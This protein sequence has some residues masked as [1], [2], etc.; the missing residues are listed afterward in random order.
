MHADVVDTDGEEL[1]GFTSYD[2]SLEWPEEILHVM[3]ACRGVVAQVF[4]SLRASQPFLPC[5]G[6]ESRNFGLELYIDEE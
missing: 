6:L 4:H 3:K 1:Q 2:T 5:I